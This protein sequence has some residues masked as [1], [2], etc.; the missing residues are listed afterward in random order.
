MCTPS[1]PSP[2]LQAFQLCKN[3]DDILC[4]DVPPKDRRGCN[5]RDRSIVNKDMT[6][7]ELYEFAK[8]CFE[9]SVTSFTQFFTE[10]IPELVRGI[11]NASITAIEGNLWDKLRGEWE[12]ARSLAADI[13]EAVRENPAAY[14]A[15]IWDRIVGVA[16]EQIQNFDCLKPEVKV[17][18]T[19]SFVVGYMMPPMILAKLLVKGY[20]GIKGVDF[21]AGRKKLDLQL[22]GGHLAHK[23]INAFKSLYGKEL[24]LPEGSNKRF[25]LY[26]K[27]QNTLNAKVLYFDVENA[28]QKK[29]ND[30]VFKDKGL[31]DA[32]NNS[33][34]SKF[35]DLLDAHP[36]LKSRLQGEYKDYKSFRLRLALKEGDDPKKFT[37]M[38][39]DL[40]NKAAQNFADDFEK[41]GMN[42][43]IPPMTDEAVDP[44][45]WFLAGI[46]D[47]PLEANMAAR[48]A[49]VNSP[50]TVQTF[51]NQEKVLNRDVSVIENLRTKL[52]GDPKLLQAGVL[53]KTPEGMIPSKEMVEILRKNKPDAFMTAEEYSAAIKS[54]VK[55]MFGKDIDDG[56]VTALTNYYQKVDSLSPPLFVAE[57]TVINLAEAERGIVSVDFA[58]AGVNNAFEQMR[59]LAQTTNKP[60]SESLEKI[61]SRVDGV[62]VKMDEGKKFFDDAVKKTSNEK[63]SA[64]FSGDDGIFMPKS[65]FMD[66]DKY[67]LIK[68]LGA[69]ESPSQ[70]RVTFVRSEY[71]AGKPIPAAERTKRI[72]QAESIEKKLREAVTKADGITSQQGQKMLFAIDYVPKE[73]GGTFNLIIGG[74]KPTAAQLKTIEEAYKKLLKTE[75]GEHLGRIVVP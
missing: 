47:T 12:S 4:T 11:W 20:K 34:M 7:N 33:F 40:Q 8:V 75:N 16:S 5:E 60:L 35:K 63:H 74:A 26:S 43:A 49:R 3:V 68:K 65:E 59:A 9:A 51:K 32:I 24:Q 71:S 45:R 14:F 70:F 42:K 21:L 62:T 27:L 69:H 56:T 1:Q 23:E 18:K 6:V 44:R 13:H 28:V 15:H 58:G 64:L 29:L 48:G 67:D 31:V 17:E 41:L 52:A 10:F 25:I 50:T 19:C 54:K 38:L 22:H 46:G 57:R 55:T 36:E 2:A 39:M 66:R 72:V 73:V 53:T 61:Q 37:K 30:I